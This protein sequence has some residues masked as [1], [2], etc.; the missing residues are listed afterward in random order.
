MKASG[1][2]EPLIVAIVLGLMTF[3]GI[4]TAGPEEPEKGI[5]TP[6]SI[7]GPGPPEAGPRPFSPAGPADEIP[8]W[9]ARWELAK[10]LSN[11]K[12]YDE[13]I[14]EYR[15]LLREK[16]ELFE[17]RV[18]M[19]T[20]LYWKGDSE[21]ALEILEKIPSKELDKSGRLLMADIYVA[22]K[23][24]EKAEPLYRAY[25]KDHPRDVSV[26]L[27]LAELLSWAGK[28]D[29]SLTAYER[30]LEIRPDDIQVRRRYAFVLVWAG[31]HEDAARELKKTLD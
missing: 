24:Y 27:K 15:K 19:A 6:D 11:V 26:Q 17:A 3:S 13:S 29:E 2:Q 23:K 22:G 31:R 30:I 25:L 20:V 21:K 18:E 12:K 7:K 10:V 4:S 16:P 14:L 8:A 28:Y 9:L 5:F 1:F